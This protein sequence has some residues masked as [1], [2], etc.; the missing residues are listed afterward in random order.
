MWV[1]KRKAIQITDNYR[2]FSRTVGLTDED[3]K[4]NRLQR[5]DVDVINV[6]DTE[7]FHNICHQ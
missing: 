4:I 5:P 6:D 7:V 1:K 2:T 3:K